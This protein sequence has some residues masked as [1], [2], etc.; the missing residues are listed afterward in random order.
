MPLLTRFER[1]AEFQQSLPFMP[2]VRL[3]RFVITPGRVPV[4]R[5]LQ[6][7][8]FTLSRRNSSLS[9]KEADSKATVLVIKGEDLEARPE[10]LLWQQ[11]VTCISGSAG[12]DA[13]F[14]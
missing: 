9:A 3:F 6:C 8:L 11:A 1:L 14:V 12:L 10:A 4:Q 5:P 2:T 7:V 13:R